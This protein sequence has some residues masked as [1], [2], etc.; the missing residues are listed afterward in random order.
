[1]PPLSQVLFNERA[2]H[3]KD[4]NVCY[5]MKYGVLVGGDCCLRTMSLV[6]INGGGRIQKDPSGVL[7]LD[8]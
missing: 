7:T 1:M 3:Y 4:V 8:K 6:H 2:D 5:E